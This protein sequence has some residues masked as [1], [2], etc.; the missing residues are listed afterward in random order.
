MPMGREMASSAAMAV[1]LHGFLVVAIVFTPQIFRGRYRPLPDLGPIMVSLEG[2]GGPRGGGA[3]AAR[4]VAAPL[5]EKPAPP[6]KAAPV[7]S[8]AR[9]ADDLAIPKPGK[10]RPAAK[11]DDLRPDFGPVARPASPA[12]P[13]PA[14]VGPQT[15]TSA[16]G[17]V[18]S[19]A[20]PAGNGP[21]VDINLKTP[22]GSGGSGTGTDTLLYYFARIQDKVSAF[23]MPAALGDRE[24]VV[25][26]GIRLQHNGQVREITIEQSSGDRGFDDAAIRA[27]RQAM[28]LPPFPA[29]VKEDSM[30]LILKF[31]NKGIGG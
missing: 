4:P 3:A 23:W 15:A 27:L 25:L 26:V 28:P 7:P 10:A 21:S 13:A 16:P 1:A 19:V 31:T 24:V 14:R 20:G 17:P 12:P 22:G 18:A 6:A 30:N 5:P 9:P 11:T 2:S 29:L 8:R